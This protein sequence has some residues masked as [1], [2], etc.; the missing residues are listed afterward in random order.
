VDNDPELI[1][2]LEAI[3]DAGFGEEHRR[4]GV[5]LG[6]RSMRGSGAE[7]SWPAQHLDLAGVVERRSI[8]AVL[9]IVVTR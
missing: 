2:A 8:V 9:P 6:D 4:L 1:R 5:Q 7:T 3:G